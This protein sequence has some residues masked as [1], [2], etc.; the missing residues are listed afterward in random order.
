M[1]NPPQPASSI[2]AAL[3]QRAAAAADAYDDY[4]AHCRRMTQWAF[5]AWVAGRKVYA[6][7]R[8]GCQHC[9]QGRRG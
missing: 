1:A 9:S 4:C 3:V 8:C 6:C 7:A 5:R 2:F